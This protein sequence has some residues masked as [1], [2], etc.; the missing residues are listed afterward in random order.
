MT[1]KLPLLMNS[2]FKLQKQ[3]INNFFLIL[4]KGKLPDDL[5]LTM[6][7]TVLNPAFLSQSAADICIDAS[8]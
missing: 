7:G 6:G 2:M 1:Y 4:T 8:N 5:Q 3:F